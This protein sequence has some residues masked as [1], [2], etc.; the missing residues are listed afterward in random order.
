MSTEYKQKDETPDL[1]NILGLTTDVC[2]EPNCDVLI[3]KA[4][5]KKAKLCYPDKHPGRK[6]IRDLFELITNAYDIL[7]NE[8]L[9]KDYNHKLSLNRQSSGDF[10]K[11]KKS[12]KDHYDALGEYKEATDDQKISFKEQMKQ[13]DKKHGY[14]PSMA[15]VAIPKGEARKKVNELRGL[16]E[17]QDKELM[18]QRMFHEGV[19][20]PKKFNAAFDKIHNR[21]Q[22]TMVSHN[23][24]PSAWN[25]LGTTANYSNFDNLDNLYVETGDRFDTGRDI[26]AGVDFGGPAKQLGIDEM[27][28]I[29]GADYFDGHGNLGDDYYKDIKQKLRDRQASTGNIESMKFGDFKRDDTAGYGIFDQLGFSVDDRLS[30]DVDEDDISKRF[31][32]MMAERQKDLLPG[33]NNS[34][35]VNKKS[36]QPRKGTR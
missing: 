15:D 35:N 10:L 4:Y 1:Y 29:K 27:N 30:L 23:G 9:R 14:D 3:Q 34:N 33:N 16:R 25:D 21:D 22:G 6:D 7:K 19:F 24:I 5:V 28:D 11:L 32:K 12:T 17:T 2:K 8:K 18:P 31:E 26:Y 20:D 13:L 36:S